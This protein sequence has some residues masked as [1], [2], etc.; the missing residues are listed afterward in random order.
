[1]TTATLDRKYAMTRMLGAY[2]LPSND[3]KTLWRINSYHED[4][5]AE[6]SD[7]TPIV[8]KFWAT[9]KR[10]MP[11][12]ADIQRCDTEVDFVWYDDAWVA[13]SFMHKTRAEAI[14]EALRA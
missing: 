3:G 10:P 4:G 14:A 13:W 9:S 12:E 6:R 8:G 1:M 5:S 2:L 11:T 7:G